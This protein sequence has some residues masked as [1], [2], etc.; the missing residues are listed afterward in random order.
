MS[1]GGRERHSDCVASGEHEGKMAAV[2]SQLDAASATITRLEAERDGLYG[3]ASY[4]M[5]RAQHELSCERGA[6][7]EAERDQLFLIVSQAQDIANHDPSEKLGTGYIEHSVVTAVAALHATAAR[8]EAE[9][10]VLRERATQLAQHRDSLQA[11]LGVGFLRAA[12]DGF[13]RR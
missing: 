13:T 8:L 3:E 4:K 11:R 2:Q 5:L 10:V 9:N 6:R 12:S 7:L 1:F